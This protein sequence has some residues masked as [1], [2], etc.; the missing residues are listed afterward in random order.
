MTQ[1]FTLREIADFPAQVLAEIRESGQSAMIADHGR[2][3][4]VIRA[5]EPGEVE[6]EV[7]PEMARDIAEAA[8]P[9]GDA[10]ARLRQEI[11]EGEQS[12][13]ASP[14]DEAYFSELRDHAEARARVQAV[15]DRYRARLLPELFQAWLNGLDDRRA[16]LLAENWDEVMTRA[17]GELDR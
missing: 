17:S 4:A 15:I 5:L 11:A 13:P 9:F 16:A 14:A 7:L 2:F 8:R 1:V 10:E 6:R 3:V 12:P